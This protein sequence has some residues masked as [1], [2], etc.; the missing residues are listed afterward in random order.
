MKD[1]AKGSGPHFC[2]FLFCCCFFVLP[3]GY[4]M[5]T[6][7]SY[8]LQISIEDNW[9][10]MFCR[11]QLKKFLLCF[12]DLSRRNFSY[13]L[14]ISIEGTS[15]FVPGDLSVYYGTNVSDV[16][17]QL[18]ESTLLSFGFW[19][20]L[21][22]E[23]SFSPFNFSCIGLVSTKPYTLVYR[24]KGKDGVLGFWMAWN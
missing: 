1:T 12:A 10:P 4:I 14:Q 21:K 5:Y 13:V 16:K 3:V 17:R 15:K 23:H 9:A 11:S 22:E 24:L 6:Y 19:L 20:K 8:V 18:S 7:F 2:P